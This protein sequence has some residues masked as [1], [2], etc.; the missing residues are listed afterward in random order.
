MSTNTRP[1][2][3]I[4]QLCKTSRG[5]SAKIARECKITPEAVYAWRQVPAWHVETVARI[6]GASPADLRPDLYPWGEETGRLPA[7]LLRLIPSG[8]RLVR[9]I[10]AERN[11]A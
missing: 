1:K 10:E 9:I 2:V 11:A 7:H 6:I 5:L 4:R 3:D 8:Y